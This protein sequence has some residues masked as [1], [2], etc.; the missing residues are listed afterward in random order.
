MAD[1]AVISW[2]HPLRANVSAIGPNIGQAVRRS[3]A[4]MHF[5]SFGPV[6]YNTA[7]TARLANY[8]TVGLTKA[9]IAIPPEALAQGAIAKFFARAAEM[10]VLTGMSGDALVAGGGMAVGAGDWVPLQIGFTPAGVQHTHI[11]AIR[12]A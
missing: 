2:H 3:G 6:L 5:E 9:E 1:E 11:L 12:L 4:Q 10:H 7:G 8:A